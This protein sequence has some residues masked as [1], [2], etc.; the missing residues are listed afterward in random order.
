MNPTE[1]PDGREHEGDEYVT[2]NRRRGRRDRP[3]FLPFPPSSEE[4][5]EALREA[6]RRAE[7]EAEK[8]LG[9]RYE[10]PEGSGK[11][12]VYPDVAFMQIISDMLA[13]QR[14]MSQSLAQVAE[15]LAMVD[16]PGT[17]GPHAVHGNSGA[18]S[19]PQSPTR[20]YTSASR[21]PRPL[22]PS[23]QRATPVATQI[24]IAQRLATHA[25]DIAEYRREYAAFGQDF[26]QDMTLVEYCGLRLW[27]L[28]RE[29]QS[30]GQQ[31]Q[32]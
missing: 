27:N 11:A 6:E 8:R 28:P 12:P 32:Q 20:T 25:E 29:P 19:R 5:E 13:S 9:D 7:R 18:G 26:H 22:F 14:T 4:V 3:N 16:I 10:R 30:G 31:Q 17:Q 23:F 15:R 1:E 24:P 2:Y 21:I